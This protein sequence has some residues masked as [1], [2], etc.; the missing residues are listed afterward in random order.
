MWSRTPQVH[1]EHH[2]VIMG[3]QTALKINK[4]H[5]LWHTAERTST[6]IW[7]LIRI[8]NSV[9]KLSYQNVCSAVLAQLM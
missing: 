9:A 7:I 1:S 5:S 2:A 3:F 4:P 6:K 8:S